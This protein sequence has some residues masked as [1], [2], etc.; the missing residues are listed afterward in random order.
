[1]PPLFARQREQH[2]LDLN[3]DARRVGRPDANCTPP[4]ATLRHSAR[5]LVGHAKCRYAVVFRG[6]RFRAHRGSP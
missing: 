6:W 5:A 2:V 4:S 1:M 3:V